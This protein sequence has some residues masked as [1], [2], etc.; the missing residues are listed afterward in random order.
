M[1]I[2]KPR[3]WNLGIRI[4]IGIG[5]GA[6]TTNAIFSSSIRPMVIKPNRVVI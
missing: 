1:A 2:C 6:D 5:I 4:G 3:H